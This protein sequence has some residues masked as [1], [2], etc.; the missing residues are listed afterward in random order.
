MAIWA[1]EWPPA[2]AGARVTCCVKWLN[3]QSKPFIKV[4]AATDGEA[5]LAPLEEAAVEL[6]YGGRI[7]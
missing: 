5:F 6:E 2:D 3:P 1:S 7:F 4:V